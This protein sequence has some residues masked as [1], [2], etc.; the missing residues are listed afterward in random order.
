MKEFKIIVVMF[1]LICLS[2][3]NQTDVDKSA[4]VE[5]P[6]E[7]EDPIENGDPIEIEDPIENG[8]LIENGDPCKCEDPVVIE[9]PG[10]TYLK[11]TKWKLEG[12]VDA[13]TGTLKVLEP[14]DCE[15]EEFKKMLGLKDCVE[16]YC[17]TFDTDSIFSFH[18]ATNLLHAIFYINYNTMCFRIRI[19]GGT[20]VNAF[21]DERLFRETLYAVQSFSFQEN[22]LK[23]YYNDEKNYLLFKRIKS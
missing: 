9:D 21:F 1:F 3:Q 17:P 13:E 5:E 6:T 12:L 14:K 18:T 20:K 11:G 7:I 10:Q 15:N 4:I 2:C 22:E 16:C 8:D 23:L 19:I